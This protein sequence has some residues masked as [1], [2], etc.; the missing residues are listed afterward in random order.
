MVAEAGFIVKIPAYAL[1]ALLGLVPAMAGAAELQ[2][3]TLNAWDLYRRLTEQRIDGELAP[4]EGF[5]I[6][7]FLP[8]GE[9]STVRRSIVMGNVFIR[10]METRNEEGGKIEIPDGLIHH[11]YGSVF[12]PDA[13][14][15]EVLAWEQDYANHKDY[16]EDVEDS[17]L[18]SRRGDVFEIF[19][20]LRRK[21]II[22]VY[23]NTDH[24]VTYRQLGPGEATSRSEATRIAELEDANTPR[25]REKPP[26][27][28]RGFMWR[29][30][31]YWRFK[32]EPDGVVVECESISL[33]RT[34]PVAFR[35]VVKP[36]ISSVPHES[37]EATL[38]P[39]REALTRH[40]ALIS[41]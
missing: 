18:I 25:E 37:L 17:R 4:Q 36:F 8:D 35:W 28:D 38:R 13:K 14:L 27:D 31:S 3:E 9:A 22:T 7:D 30:H 10:K 2:E 34:I 20:R 19:L 29:L 26:G 40:G 12:V 15:K 24:I 5:L 41:R 11:W 23:Y 21:K 32:Q 1:V 6:R 39:L 33:S 16:F